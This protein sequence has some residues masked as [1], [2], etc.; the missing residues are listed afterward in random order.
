MHVT[1]ILIGLNDVGIPPSTKPEIQ[2]VLNKFNDNTISNIN[3]KIK[4]N[5]LIL[6]IFDALKLNVVTFKM[7]YLQSD[8]VFKIY[9]FSKFSLPKPIRKEHSSNRT[10]QD[11]LDLPCTSFDSYAETRGE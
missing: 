6:G 8:L 11:Y 7:L 5:Y 9:T 2:Y 10:R 3:A 4:F 1:V